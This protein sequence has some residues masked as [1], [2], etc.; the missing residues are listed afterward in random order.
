MFSALVR[1]IT[2]FQLVTF[3]KELRDADV[4]PDKRNDGR[5][6][7]QDRSTGSVVLDD[8]PFEEIRDQDPN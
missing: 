4:P 8:V 3:L 1:L 6:H 5:I 7:D 2:L